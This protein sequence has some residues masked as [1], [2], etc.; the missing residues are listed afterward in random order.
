[1]EIKQFKALF[2]EYLDKIKIDV[3]DSKIEKFFDYMNLLISWNQKI[4]LTAIT[5]E[6]EIIIKHF[7]DSLTINK[8]IENYNKIYD[9]GS[10]AGFPGIPLK[11]LNDNKEFTLIDALNKRIVF[12]N[13]IKDKLE[14]KQIELIHGRVEDLAKNIEYREKGEVVVSRAVAN[15]ST[16]VEY[17]LPF[18]KIGGICICMKGNNI[19]EE[20]KN[21]EKAINILGGELENIDNFVLPGSDLERN[22]VIIR[23][24]KN[25][26]S[27]YPRKAGIPS[28]KPL[29]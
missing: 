2:K 16:L 6:K 20:L 12:L 10:G 22:I 23:K 19:S 21:A 3:E 15:L 17:M 4:N 7:I 28:K 5:E 13:E 1:M 11:I 26:S 24:I 29:Q 27:K 18:V 14:L 9:I 25:T 8:Y